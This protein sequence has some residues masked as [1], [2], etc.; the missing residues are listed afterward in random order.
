MQC[1]RCGKR[2]SSKKALAKHLQS[3]E[4]CPC[5]EGRMRRSTLLKQLGSLSI[6]KQ[7]KGGGS[8][9]EFICLGGY[10]G[11]CSGNLS[12]YL[13]KL[14]GYGKYICLDGGSPIDG[15][16]KYNA[17]FA[18]KNASIELSIKQ[19]D[20]QILSLK[21]QRFTA[22]DDN[23][24]AEANNLLSKMIELRNYN[25]TY[26]DNYIIPENIEAFLLSHAHLDHI[27][28]YIIATAGFHI[29]KQIVANSDVISV[30]DTHIFNNKIWPAVLKPQIIEVTKENNI[31][32][33]DDKV[34]VS[35]IP[36]KHGDY[37]NSSAF[38]ITEIE[39]SDT[40]LYF[41]DVS[42][43]PHKTLQTNTNAETQLNSVWDKAADY[44]IKKT[45]RAIFIECAYKKNT[46]K[47][48]GHLDPDQ[49]EVVLN[50][51]LLKINQKSSQD[52]KPISSLPILPGQIPANTKVKPLQDI[53]LV[54]THLKPDNFD[55]ITGM[56]TIVSQLNFIESKFGM[57]LVVPK[58][59]DRY[60]LDKDG[61]KCIK[62]ICKD[63]I[64]F[65]MTKPD[66]MPP[67]E[68]C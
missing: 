23:N 56:N 51:F 1:G 47:L 36:V 31:K 19:I 52:S 29:P 9:F 50:N 33:I 55:D 11:V 37:D 27:A 32:L 18:P 62:S 38:F 54:V 66:A 42:N 16:W 14:N 67:P 13:L 7:Q 60:R 63:K 10:G 44:V 25:L 61:P 65:N 21:F 17:N 34:I 4:P 43:K 58:Q 28:G 6:K 41:G 68:F 15:I 5:K 64:P 8:G 35:Y 3:A 39:G 24:N 46:S 57:K 20:Q 30:L 12:C 48:F 2:C 45:L 26:A 53:S 59:C 22:L 49:L 40:V